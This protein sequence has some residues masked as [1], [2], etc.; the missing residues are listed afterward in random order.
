MTIGWLL[1]KEFILQEY[2][3]DE[4]KCNSMKFHQATTVSVKLKITC[5]VSRGIGEQPPSITE[6]KAKQGSDTWGEITWRCVLGNH[7]YFEPNE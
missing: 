2:A 3:G 7:Q 5:Y 1:S 4:M 6:E